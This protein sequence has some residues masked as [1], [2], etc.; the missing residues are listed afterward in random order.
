MTTPQ[1]RSEN[2]R[3]ILMLGCGNMGGALLTPWSRVPGTR[4]TA[5]SRS[6][7]RPLPEGVGRTTKADNLEGQQFDAIVIATKPQDVAGALPAYLGLLAKD[8][9]LLSL[10]AGMSVDSISALA[11][12]VP[13]IRVMPNL[14]VSV[15]KGT[16]GITCGAG[17]QE[18]HRELVAALMAP[19]GRA[20]WVDSEDELDRLTAIAGSGPGYAL[21][22]A[23]CWTEAAE[24]LGF[25]NAQAREMVL[26]T[27]EGSAHYALSRGSPLDRLRDEV[28]SRK[29]T[30]EAGLDALNADAGLDALLDRTLRAAYQRA[31]ELR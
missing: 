14:P 30:T 10:A 25:S 26:S 4:F 5:A 7:Q 19:T 18:P 13:V 24:R 15:G 16:S 17:V 6:G 9:F 2:S 27:L 20:F 23:R 3:N 28:T 11:G 8:G 21:E 1:A 31:T 22:I 29:G 12:G